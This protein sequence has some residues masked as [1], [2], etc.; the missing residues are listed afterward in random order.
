M[1][2]VSSS[3]RAG[4]GLI[5]DLAKLNDIKSSHEGFPDLFRVATFLNHKPLK[6]ICFNLWIRMLKAQGIKIETSHAITKGLLQ[7]STV[8]N[9]SGIILV[10]RNIEEVASSLAM[11]NTVPFFTP[12]GRKYLARHSFMFV[13]RKSEL[14][15]YELCIAY[16]L[17]QRIYNFFIKILLKSRKI[18]YF[19]VEFTDLIGEQGQ[20]D[21]ILW[22]QQ[23]LGAELGEIKTKVSK[24]NSKKYK[25]LDFSREFF[26]DKIFDVS[27]D[28]ASSMGVRTADFNVGILRKELGEFTN[29]SFC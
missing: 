18:P 21:L 16:A 5:A 24:S 27:L 11:L 9:V 3:G 4:S 12:K 29:V 25:K 10:R 2:L 20:N 28:Y 7:F 23:I 17:D 19:E 8:N 22:C 15:H 14:T 1:I 6:Y 26:C 13:Q